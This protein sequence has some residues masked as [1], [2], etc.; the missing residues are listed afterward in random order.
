[1]GAKQTS[2]M[3][4]LTSENDPTETLGPAPFMDGATEP[5]GIVEIVSI[6]DTVRRRH[7]GSR[8]SGGGKSIS[9]SG[10]IGSCCHPQANEHHGCACH[11]SNQ[12]PIGSDLLDK[13]IDRKSR[14]PH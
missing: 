7:A 9:H 10:T 14:N 12:L 6:A 1:M 5:I 13:Y 8:R 11:P 3:G 4:A 2:P